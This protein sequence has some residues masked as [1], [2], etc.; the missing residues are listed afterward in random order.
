MA[1]YDMEIVEELTDE[2]L[3]PQPIENPEN[4]EDLYGS[5]RKC[6]TLDTIT[7]FYTDEDVQRYIDFMDEHQYKYNIDDED[8]ICLN[9]FNHLEEEYENDPEDPRTKFSL[10]YYLYR[11]FPNGVWKRLCLGYITPY[12]IPY[13]DGIYDIEFDYNLECCLEEYQRLPGDYL[14]ITLP[15]TDL[16]IQECPFNS[17]DYKE[18]FLYKLI[19]D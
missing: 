10:Y 13:E 7:P 9:D 16:D 8:R 4:P 19:F 18:G 11:R 12:A 14:K 2:I 17:T 3:N 15:H 5:I 6:V 1:Y